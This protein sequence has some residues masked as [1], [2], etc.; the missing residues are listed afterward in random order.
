VVIG[1]LVM[2][3]S[4]WGSSIRLNEVMAS[5]GSTIA[6]EDGDFED[7]IEL[8]NF[9]DTPVCLGGWWLSD[10]YEEPQKWAFPEPTTLN[11]GEYLL[12]WA[13]GKDDVRMPMQGFW[14]F[15][16]E[17]NLI[18]SNRFSIDLA[19]QLDGT[20]EF[21]EGRN[22]DSQALDF[23][24]AGQVNLSDEIRLAGDFTVAY[25]FYTR[26]SW[27]WHAVSSSASSLR[28]IGHNAASR[29]DLWNPSV[30]IHLST[31]FLTQEW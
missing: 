28:P 23:P 18:Q 21:V 29:I 17:S 24:G 14:D 22:P 3:V 2:T 26:R 12:L 1:F 25:W 5:N 10:D 19:A 16:D 20:V 4:A 30:S 11:P 9:G 31:P 27:H 7:W 6:D 13:S 8:Y 15:A